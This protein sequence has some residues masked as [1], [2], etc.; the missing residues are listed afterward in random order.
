M[1][2]WYQNASRQGRAVND[3]AFDPWARAF[4][5][6]RAA[7]ARGEVPVGAVLVRGDALLAADGNRT[8]LEND[9]TGHAEIRAIRSACASLE[10]QRLPDCDLYVT[11]EPCAMC[12]AAISFARIRRLYLAAGDPKA[13]A[14]DHGPRFFGQ[15]TCHHRPD[16]YGGFR[17]SEAAALLRGFFQER[18]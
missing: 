5:E 18:R 8:L 16:V 6:A 12:A 4:D 10:S 13:G 1:A 2:S 7:G 9:P 15:P 3:R 11:L 14:V 17:E